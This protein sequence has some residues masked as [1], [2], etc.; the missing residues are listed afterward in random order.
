MKKNFLK[1]ALIVITLSV[2]SCGKNESARVAPTTNGISGSI[3]KFAVVDN[4]LYGLNDNEI[5]VYDI[6][7]NN[8]A[9]K[10]GSTEVGYNI[11]TIFSLQDNLY[12]GATDGIYIVD[13][14]TRNKPI[15]LSKAIHTLGCDPVIV[16]GNIAFS[17]VRTGVGCGGNFV[18]YSAL[19]IYDVRNINYP[20]IINEYPMASPKGLA[21]DG[22]TLFV[23]D[24]ENGLKIFDISDIRT[25]REVTNL[26]EI[27]AKDV[28]AD[29]NTLVV[30]TK[31]GYVFYD[32][33]DLQNIQLIK[34][35]H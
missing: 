33:S 12:I 10:V 2:A 4:F 5:V 6:S 8:D 35:I 13:I 27:N 3:T 17:T 21:Y 14:T 18:Q 9:I 16:K 34:T 24:E 28:I 29:N 15:V 22:N 20:V 11:E 19:L 1:M 25:I 7:N 31:N 23:C 26:K 32:Y 30:S